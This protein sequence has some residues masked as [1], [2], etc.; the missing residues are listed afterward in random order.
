MWSDEETLLQLAGHL[1][2]RA[3]EEWNLLEDCEKS[4]LEG[5]VSALKKRLEP[6]KTLAAQDF[7]RTGQ[8][9]QE[10]V[11]DYIRRL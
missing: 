1:R 7:R 9:D 10:T 5:A 2:G 11:S 3:L 4:S 6:S 8:R